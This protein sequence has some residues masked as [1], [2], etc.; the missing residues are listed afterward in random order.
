MLWILLFYFQ[1]Y[2]THGTIPMAFDYTMTASINAW[3][4]AIAMHGENLLCNN[5]L[6]LQL[7]WEAIIEEQRSSSTA[8]GRVG[9]AKTMQN[10]IWFTVRNNVLFG[11]LY[12]MSVYNFA[13]G[14]L[15]FLVWDQL[16]CSNKTPFGNRQWF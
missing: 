14:N 9:P 6:Y 4:A 16:F 10:C 3:A 8:V 11:I 12:Y 7:N 1:G 13:I 15:V 2:A 5:E